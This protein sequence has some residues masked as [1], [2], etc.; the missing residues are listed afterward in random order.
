MRGIALR[1]LR[2]CIK[3]LLV[4]KW[5]PRLRD[6]N[7]P[8]CEYPLVYSALFPTAPHP[9]LQELFPVPKGEQVAA[10]DEE[11]P[12]E[13]K[14]CQVPVGKYTKGSGRQAS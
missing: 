8:E 14:H 13:T 12:L 9:T 2:N 11:R 5:D 10:L 4:S 1:R 6:G 3:A 7:M